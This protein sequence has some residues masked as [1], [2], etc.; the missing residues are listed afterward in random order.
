M[1]SYRNPVLREFCQRLLEVGKPKKLGCVDICIMLSGCQQS[2]YLHNN[3]QMCLSSFVA[4]QTSTSDGKP[5]VDG[6]SRLSS[7]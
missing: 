7:G 5:N 2:R 3:D 1:A 4:S 6:S